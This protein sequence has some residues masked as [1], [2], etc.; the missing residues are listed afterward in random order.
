MNTLS[1]VA[2]AI[3]VMATVS[4]CATPQATLTVSTVPEGAV[5]TEARSGLALGIAPVVSVYNVADLARFKRNDGC[6]YVNGMRAQWA[7]GAIS[8]IPEIRLCG[9][10]SGAY[11]IALARDMS[12]PGLDTDLEFAMKAALV[13]A[14]IAQANAA[15][16]MADMAVLRNF[17]FAAPQAVSCTSTQIGNTVQTSCR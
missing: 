8:Q 1:K 14:Q 10:V 16:T 6:Y 3:A 11:N 15:T 13:R 2:L 17:G 9:S 4:G 5:V 7:S 12:L